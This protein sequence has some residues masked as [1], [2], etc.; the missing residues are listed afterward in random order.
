MQ[1]NGDACEILP[2]GFVA[3]FCCK[4]MKSFSQVDTKSREYF[5]GFQKGEYCM[6]CFGVEGEKNLGP[7]Y[8]S[9]GIHS[10]EE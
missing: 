5:K 1:K 3:S 6:Y 9:A 2:G 10:G 4:L 7:G 8:G